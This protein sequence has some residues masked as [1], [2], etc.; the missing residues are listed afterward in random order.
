M[1]RL[2]RDYG[3]DAYWSDRY[4][5]NL[6]ARGFEYE[7]EPADLV[8]AFEAFEHFVE[9]AEELDR[10]LSIAPNVLLSTEIIADPAPPQDEWWYYGIE[11]GQHIGFFRVRTLKRLA[12]QRGKHFATNGSSYHLI[13]QRPI[14]PRVWRL[15][16]KSR[17]AVSFWARRLLKSKTL[18]D[19]SFVIAGR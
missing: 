14:N 9:P 12:E 19:H 18:A 13:S 8:T 7:G 1:V 16:I 10:L 5:E 4:C 6:V 3:V 2:L 17:T 11:H 15:L